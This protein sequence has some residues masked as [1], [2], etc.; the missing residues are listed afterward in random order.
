LASIGRYKLGGLVKVSDV[1]AWSH[2][3]GQ[4]IGS[5]PET[6]PS[7]TAARSPLSRNAG[8]GCC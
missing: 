8:E 1:F 2:R 3:V 5:H 7:P 4:R 6:H